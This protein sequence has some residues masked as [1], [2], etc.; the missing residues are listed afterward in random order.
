[1][2]ITKYFMSVYMRPH[3]QGKIWRSKT[4]PWLG[5]MASHSLWGCDVHASVHGSRTYLHPQLS[6]LVKNTYDK[7]CLVHATF[8]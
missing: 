5:I 2:Y 4:V 3:K 1:M 7:M 6:S 8:S